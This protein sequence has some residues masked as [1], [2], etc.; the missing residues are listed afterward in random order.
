MKLKDIINKFIIVELYGNEFCMDNGDF[1]FKNIVWDVN[2]VLE[3]VYEKCNCCFDN[4]SINKSI[5]YYFE[6]WFKDYF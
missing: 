3:E 2:E 1:V 4:V 5:G 6:M